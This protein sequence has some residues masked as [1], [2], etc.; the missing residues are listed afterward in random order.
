MS[1]QAITT[2][3]QNY[4]NAHRGKR[5]AAERP[6]PRRSRTSAALLAADPTGEAPGYP[7][8]ELE[9]GTVFLAG[10]LARRTV[11]QDSVAVCR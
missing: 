11:L 5:P 6:L 10:A 4:G 2:A 9:L 3:A 7:F 1:Y 8:R